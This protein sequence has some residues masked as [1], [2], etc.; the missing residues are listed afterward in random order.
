MLVMMMMM[1]PDCFCGMVDQ[2]K[3]FINRDHCQIFSQSQIFD[4]PRAG[5]KSSQN[6]SSSFVELFPKA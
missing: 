4:T 3:A 2:Q 5:V 1:T 6:L